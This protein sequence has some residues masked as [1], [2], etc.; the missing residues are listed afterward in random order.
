MPVG[1]CS[2]G[3][4]GVNATCCNDKLGVIIAA[5]VGVSSTSSIS[6]SFTSPA[7]TSQTQGSE[8][9]ASLVSS[10]TSSVSGINS[11]SSITSSNT[12]KPSSTASSGGLDSGA[13]IGV[14]VG[15]AWGVIAITAIFG[16]FLDLQRRRASEKLQDGTVQNFVPYYE[17]RRAELLDKHVNIELPA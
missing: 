1:Q 17:G 2:D 5:T 4:W 3:S 12:S 9:P 11:T 16:A 13:K 8:L 6:T 10:S 15:V 7:P 14:G